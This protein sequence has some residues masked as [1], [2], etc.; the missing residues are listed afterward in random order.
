[1]KTSRG[2]AASTSFVRFIPV[3]LDYK[4]PLIKL[5]PLTST[6]KESPF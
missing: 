5:T 4:L 6:R 1:V 2:K 3:G